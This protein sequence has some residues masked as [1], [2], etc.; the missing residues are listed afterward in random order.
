VS[1]SCLFAIVLLSIRFSTAAELPSPTERRF[2]N[3]RQVEVFEQRAAALC[4]EARFDEASSVVADGLELCRTLS[5]QSWKTQHLVYQ[6]DSYT[7]MAALPIADQQALAATFE[8]PGVR[9]FGHDAAMAWIE[10]L[11]EG[12][13]VRRRLHGSSSN[14][15]ADLLVKYG[16]AITHVY[17]LRPAAGPALEEALRIRRAHWPPN[18]LLV[19]E[20]MA[21]LAEWHTWSGRPKNGE[22][23]ASHALVGCQDAPI[24]AKAQLAFAHWAVANGNSGQHRYKDTLP[25]L[26]IA[27]A[28][29]KQDASEHP[30]M[31]G[32]LETQ[33]G[34]ICL[35]LSRYVEA[36]VM[37]R[38][39]VQRVRGMD[40]L[41]PHLAQLAI[42]NFALF[43]DNLGKHAEAITLYQEV[44]SIAEHH[45]ASERTIA[46]E[47]AAIGRSYAL[48]RDFD[49][50]RKFQRAAHDIRVKHQDSKA[51][52]YILQHMARTDVLDGKVDAAEIK[53][54]EAVDLGMEGVDSADRNVIH[55]MS[56]LG[57]MYY[58]RGDFDCAES[59][60]VAALN[61]RVVY[62]GDDH[63]LVAK[64]LRNTF[65]PPSAFLAG[66]RANTVQQSLLGDDDHRSEET[67]HG[68]ERHRCN[69]TV[70]VNVGVLNDVFRGDLRTQI[71][72][73]SPTQVS[74]QALVS[75]HEQL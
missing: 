21:A 32:H 29:L 50:A 31:F 3:Y 37:L 26:S 43:Q 8:E 34:L 2:E 15:V 55:C 66:D 58:K 70:D 60:H 13:A 5:G 44:L 42:H 40:T 30:V 45:D 59:Y 46:A 54:L 51:L 35:N 9:L 63:A 75:P 52:A 22:T 41:D 6:V 48:M 39:A 17:D 23:F 20:A 25:H 62:Y 38:R 19:A 24:I 28:L 49:Q 18:N 4:R 56:H 71:G 27:Y 11:R 1:F 57:T 72:G 12:L 47:Q 68:L 73:D 16:R 14:E 61:S 65:V 74:E 7:R 69:A 64:S 53:F 10:R 36:E 33:A 67:L